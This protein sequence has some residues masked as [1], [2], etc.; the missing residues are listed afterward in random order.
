MLHNE[1]KLI[2]HVK[3]QQLLI[4]AR[5]S[6]KELLQEDPSLTKQKNINIK[7]N[8]NI[9]RKTKYKWSRIS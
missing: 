8:L 6:S 3:D 7:N 4:L 9:I 5:E 1:A 2:T